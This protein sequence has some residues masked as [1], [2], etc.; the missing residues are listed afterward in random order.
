[1]QS[2]ALLART[3]AKGAAPGVGLPER[4]SRGLR[5]ASAPATRS[6]NREFQS[7]RVQFR[8]VGEERLI[9]GA[10]GPVRRASP[11]KL[12]PPGDTTTI[13]SV[14]LPSPPANG[15]SQPRPGLA[16]SAQPNE[17]ERRRGRGALRG[18]NRDAVWGHTVAAAGLR[19][20]ITL[21][22]SRCAVRVP[23]TSD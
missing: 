11:T 14:L 13:G 7:A 3:C 17:G 10:S 4:V 18:Q 5:V 2:H 8:S 15:S 23:N 19:R 16:A 22:E 12:A 9:A 6:A 21:R 1:M 20:T